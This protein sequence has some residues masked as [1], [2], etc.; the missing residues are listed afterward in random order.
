MGRKYMGPFTGHKLNKC[1]EA[2]GDRFACRFCSVHFKSG[3]EELAR[4][5]LRKEHPQI[6]L[7]GVQRTSISKEAKRSTSAGKT[8]AVEPHDRESF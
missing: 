3:E 2:H 7:D 5:H 8:Q 1:F 6:G 4:Q